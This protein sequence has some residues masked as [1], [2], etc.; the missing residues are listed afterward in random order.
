MERDKPFATVTKTYFGDQKGTTNLDKS[1]THIFFK[2]QSPN[3]P[4]ETYPPR[5]TSF[6]LSVT[7]IGDR[8]WNLT[9]VD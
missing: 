7:P 3:T 9:V 4:R 8:R 2:H 6:Q 5:T 1:Y